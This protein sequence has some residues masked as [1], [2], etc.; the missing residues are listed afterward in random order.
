LAGRPDGGGAS[1]A[2]A[3]CREGQRGRW[4]LYTGGYL[5]RVSLAL[6]VC[7][8]A[9]AGWGACGGAGWG[10]CPPGTAP[11]EGRRHGPEGGAGALRAHVEGSVAGATAAQ[12][13]GR[14]RSGCRGLV[15]EGVGSGAARRQAASLRP[16]KTSSQR[17][18]CARRS[19]A[20]T[21][22]RAPRRAARRGAAPRRTTR[23]PRGRR[24]R[25]SPPAA[26]R[27]RRRRGQRR[28][29]VS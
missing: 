5:P 10:P 1:R 24:A 11:Q 12:A 22:R 13:A 6:Y 23:P 15:L 21:R 20:G 3:G 28:R 26:R 19:P 14:T 9:V 17:R 8:H 27:R 4:R 2:R 7:W 29:R 16:G 25:P 18:P